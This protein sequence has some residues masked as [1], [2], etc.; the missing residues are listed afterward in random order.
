MNSRNSKIK[1]A[2]V[3]GCRNGSRCLNIQVTLLSFIILKLLWLYAPQE[4]ILNRN[5]VDISCEGLDGTI[6]S[7][8][9]SK[10]PF[11]KFGAAPQFPSGAPLRRLQ[12]TNCP[13]SRH[14]VLISQHLASSIHIY[15]LGSFLDCWT[16]FYLSFTFSL[17]SYGL[18]IWPHFLLLKMFQWL[19]TVFRIKTKVLCWTHQVTVRLYLP[20]QPY[21]SP[22][23]SLWLSSRMTF[24]QVVTAGSSLITCC[25]HWLHWSSVTNQPYGFQAM[26]GPLSF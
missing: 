14:T 15:V 1:L 25:C 2:A 22:H 12:V 8:W 21:C 3:H 20:G 26:S 16:I 6:P 4:Q 10:S 17:L 5:E 11:D 23:T 24:R 13:R 18:L 19:S 9:S 7:N